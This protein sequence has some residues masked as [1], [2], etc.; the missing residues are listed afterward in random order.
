MSNEYKFT[1]IPMTEIFYNENSYYGIY[2]FSTSDDIPNV[3]I[4]P[5][6]K[7]TKIGTLVGKMQRLTLGVPYTCTANIVM[8]KK[9]KQWQYDAVSLQIDK[10]NTL[11]EKER[12][13]KC[14]LTENQAKSLIS[15]YPDIIERV[16]NDEE[17]DLSII[18]GIG[19]KSFKKIREKILDNYVLSDVITM[20]KPY[21]VTINAIKKLMQT[22]KS[23][24]LLKQKLKTNPYILTEIKGFGFKKVDS[25][26]LRINP[27][28]RNSKQRLKA[29]INFFLTEV[30]NN[31]GHSRVDIDKLTE[32]IKEN[33]SECIMLY[34]KLLEDEL[35]SPSFLYIENNNVSL[36]KY[37]KREKDIY[38]ILLNLNKADC[39]YKLN[40]SIINKAYDD[41]KKERGYDLVIEQ[42][43]ILNKLND[44]NVVLLTGRAGSGKSSAIDVVVKAYA[45][46]KISMCALS[47]KAVRRM[48][49]TTGIGDCK[50]IHRLLGYNGVGFENNKDNPLEADLI[51]IDEASMIN[52]SLFLSL[53]EAIPIG[54]KVLIVFDDGQLPPIGVGNIASDLLA[55][56][57]SHVALNKVHRQAKDSGILSDA[58]SIRDGINPI[59]KPT[60]MMVRGKLKDM[61]YIF[62]SNK[63]NIFDT[64]IKY[65]MKSLNSVS[66][67]DISII[68]PRKDNATNCTNTFNLRIQ[69]LLLKNEYNYIQRGEK[70][71]KL[72]A[73]LIQKV[74]NYDKNVVNGEVGFLTEINKDKSF[75]VN[76]DGKEVEYELKDMDDLELAY[77][78]TVHSMQGSQCN[79]ILFVCDTSS[80]ILLSKEL[81]YTA[82]TRASKRCLTIAEPKAFNVGI[83]I[84]AGKRNTWLKTLKKY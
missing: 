64:T 58:N 67:E 74:N 54:A 12:F 4:L 29:F 47:A 57:F 77:A 18:K 35:V 50:T 22:E 15:V 19:D 36:Y 31:E 43:E 26:S 62:D 1:L 2:K 25:I 51:I 30:G 8:N 40:K 71:F 83:K 63:E 20:L 39:G 27:N 48:V 24:V 61:Y 34:N 44:N 76:F 52:S 14:I 16:V 46:K 65:F 69:D 37:Y 70:V 81:I 45:N 23:V 75:V 79:T 49:E 66:I 3:D 55:L 5:F 28:L 38:T 68:V 17:I 60:S 80:Y 78:L 32:A 73:K 21:G 10:P 6:D 41:F 42:K 82:L 84:K 11:D 9:Y 33:V 7:G 53:L 13:L 56:S 72:G 59:D